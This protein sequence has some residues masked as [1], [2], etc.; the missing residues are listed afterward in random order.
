MGAYL[1][2]CKVYGSGDSARMIG[3]ILVCP[4]DSTSIRSY[5]MNYWANSMIAYSMQQAIKA[6]LGQAWSFGPKVKRLSNMILVSEGWP[7]AKNAQ[8]QTNTSP[9]IGSRGNK[10]L[11]ALRGQRGNRAQTQYGPVG[12]RSTCE[13]MFMRHRK[14][15][16]DG[17]GHGAQGRR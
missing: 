5:A 3:G 15:R 4:D 6:G 2:G 8:G 11:S 10:S 1:G 17:E 12:D 13:L 14:S 7:T 16:N 9:T